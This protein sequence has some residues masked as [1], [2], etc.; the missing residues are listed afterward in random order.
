MMCM[1]FYVMMC[2]LCHGVCDVVDGGVSGSEGS[3]EMIDLKLFGG[4]DL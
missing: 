1:M 2:I 4:F 3:G